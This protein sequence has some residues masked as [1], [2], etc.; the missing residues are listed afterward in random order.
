M[1]QGEAAEKSVVADMHVPGETRCVREHGVPTDAAIVR[2]MTVGHDEIVVTDD[3]LPAALDS[4][5][6]QRTVLAYG[7]AI[8]DGEARGLA[9]VADM[10]WRVAER[11]KLKYTI[12]TSDAS[13]TVNH[14][15]G[16]MIEYAPTAT[17]AS[18]RA[19]ASTIAVGCITI[20]T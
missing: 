3:R 12:L 19:L 2:D 16:P 6:I 17:L 4:A 20:V 18:S 13:R 10:L 9:L 8:A 1:N 15:V 11:T 5:A 14:D 7:I